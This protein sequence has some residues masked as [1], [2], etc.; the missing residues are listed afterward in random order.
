VDFEGTPI[1]GQTPNDLFPEPEL[2]FWNYVRGLPDTLATVSGPMA[3]TVELIT[4]AV[5]VTL[6]SILSTHLLSMTAA[7]FGLLRK[8]WQM[9][10]FT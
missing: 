6:A 1:A 10:P 4:A 2:N 3:S 8:A 9:L 7:I 5:L